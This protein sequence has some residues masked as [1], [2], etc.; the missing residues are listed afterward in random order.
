MN[1]TPTCCS[2][3]SIEQIAQ[4]I[5]LS[6]RISRADQSLLMSALLSKDC[7]QPHEQELVKE[8]FQGLRSGL[9]KVVD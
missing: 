1:F 7:L 5:M 4:R 8:I 2:Q 9:I 3:V 6:R